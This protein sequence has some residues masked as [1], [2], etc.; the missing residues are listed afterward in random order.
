MFLSELG[1]AWHDARVEP[2]IAHL[3]SASAGRS[4]NAVIEAI[5]KHLLGGIPARLV[6]LRWTR[7]LKIWNGVR[8]SSPP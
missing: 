8:E 4:S 2:D 5:T 7:R 6:T 1:S 3:D